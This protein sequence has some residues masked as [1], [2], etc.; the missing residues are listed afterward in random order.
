MAKTVVHYPTDKLDV[1]IEIE[2]STGRQARFRNKRQLFSKI[3]SVAENSDHPFGT[4]SKVKNRIYEGPSI[5]VENGNGMLEEIKTAEFEPECIQVLERIIGVS[6]DDP[7]WTTGT[8]EEFR[9]YVLSTISN[10]DTLTECAGV[11]SAPLPRLASLTIYADPQATEALTTA[12]RRHIMFT[13]RPGLDRIGTGEARAQVGL[14]EFEFCM[15][16]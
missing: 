2:S 1:I 16:S 13:I 15:V 8:S 14:G 9:V 5:E 12:S 4:P 6:L 11:P 3:V 7:S 10:R